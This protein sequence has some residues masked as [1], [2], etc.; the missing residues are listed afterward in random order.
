MVIT[1]KIH[2]LHII[3]CKT[4]QNYTYLTIQRSYIIPIGKAVLVYSQN[5]I[6]TTCL[7]Y[8]TALKKQKYTLTVKHEVTNKH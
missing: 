4:F 6:S 1:I 3:N 7:F 5:K 2:V 8:N